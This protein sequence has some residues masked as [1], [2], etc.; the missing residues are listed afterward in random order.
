MLAN[1]KSLSKKF[2]ITFFCIIGLFVCSAFNEYCTYIL[3]AGCCLI[4]PFLSIQETLEL[5]LFCYPFQ[6][7]FKT[8][9][10]DNLYLLMTF[11]FTGIL[12]VKYLIEIIKRQKRINFKVLIPILIFL[13]YL[14][15]PIHDVTVQNYG[16]Y[17]FTYL[18][19]Y[20]VIIY[21][22]ELNFTKLSLAFCLGIIISSLLSVLKFVS[23]LLDGKILE[24]VSY[25]GSNYIKFTGLD[26][27]PNSLTTSVIIAMSALF[28][29]KYQNKIKDVYFVVLFALLFIVGYA[30]I[31]RAF[32]IGTG[33]L[34]V[35]FYILY[36][37]K[38]KK[39]AIPLLIITAVVFCALL[40][41]MYRETREYLCRLFEINN[42]VAVEVDKTIEENWNEIRNGTINYDPGRI[43]IYKMY[44]KDIFSS[45]SIFLFGRGI[46]ASYLGGVACHNTFLQLLWFHGLFG[47]CIYLAILFSVIKFSKKAFKQNV[48][49]ILLFLIPIFL[50]LLFESSLII[51]E[52][53][54]FIF[55]LTLSYDDN[56][57][58]AKSLKSENMVVN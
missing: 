22:K 26:V 13:I 41:I 34:L 40:L 16:R 17:C 18:L 30:T 55:A 49:K 29:C 42:Q 52:L 48:L 51:Q 24:S 25:S 33:A 28:V 4:T 47:Y 7:I 45:V 27:H 14:L 31:S 38:Y 53:F 43:G 35:L 57:G 1:I 9:H 19:V 54:I 46:S 3:V 21:R 20:L 56:E 36:F 2:Y 12:A 10:I 32:I 6:I 15:L 37:I 58:S 11:V 50:P 5:M 44:L 8:Q 23:P 39:K